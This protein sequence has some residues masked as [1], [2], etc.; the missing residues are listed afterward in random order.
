MYRRRMRERQEEC[1]FQGTRLC[2]FKSFRED[3]RRGAASERMIGAF[4]HVF[5]QMVVLVG[6][7]TERR[8][9][10]SQ[11]VIF[12]RLSIKLR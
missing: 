3:A 10:L 6:G 1:P 8:V 7:S 5:T 2:I 4:F 9:C 11:D 12:C